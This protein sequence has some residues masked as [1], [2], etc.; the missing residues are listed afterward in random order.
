MQ[1]VLLFWRRSKAEPHDT[2]RNPGLVRIKTPSWGSLNHCWGLMLGSM[3]ISKTSFPLR[4]PA[5]S[6]LISS[7]DSLQYENRKAEYFSAIW[8][9]IN[10]KAAEK[11]FE[12]VH[13][14]SQS[15]LS[16]CW[17]LSLLP[18]N[19]TRIVICSEYSWYRSEISPKNVANVRR[20]KICTG[21]S[22]YFVELTDKFFLL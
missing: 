12:W 14:G 8:N 11:R 17:L 10:W 16:S 6:S 15:D 9:V 2:N 20:T 3:L 7:T 5:A 21:P 22:L 4:V 19:S 18:I 1:W 13:K